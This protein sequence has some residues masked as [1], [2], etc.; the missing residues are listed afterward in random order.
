M[1]NKS[2][3]AQISIFQM[4]RIIMKPERPE[5]DDD[6]RRELLEFIS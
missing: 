3:N 5:L 6:E 2:P 4:L 1:V